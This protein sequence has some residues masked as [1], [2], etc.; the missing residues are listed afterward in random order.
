[1]A[2][3]IATFSAEVASDQDTLRTVTFVNQTA[4]GASITTVQTFSS[5]V[6]TATLTTNSDGSAVA[7]GDTISVSV[8]DTNAAGNSAPSNSES[9]VVPFPA[10][11]A[12]PTTPQVLTLTASA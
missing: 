2:Q 5:N 10:P 1:V 6:T 7:D 8:V 12:V 4:A 11:T 9:V 3:A